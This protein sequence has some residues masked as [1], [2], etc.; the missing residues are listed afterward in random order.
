MGLW[1]CGLRVAP[2]MIVYNFLVRF[3]LDGYVQDDGP[4]TQDRE[5]TSDVDHLVDL[6]RGVSRTHGHEKG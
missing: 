6:L 4:N 5:A 1:T 2:R 3:E